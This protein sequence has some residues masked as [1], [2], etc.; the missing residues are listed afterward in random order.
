MTKKDAVR[1]GNLLDALYAMDES[2][3]KQEELEERMK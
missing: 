1:N 2:V 3:R